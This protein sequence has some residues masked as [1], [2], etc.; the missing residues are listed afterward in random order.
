MSLDKG[1][2]S[3]GIVVSSNVTECRHIVRCEIYLYSRAGTAVGRSAIGA[4][5]TCETQSAVDI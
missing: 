5:V 2:R 3:E 1:T 4:I